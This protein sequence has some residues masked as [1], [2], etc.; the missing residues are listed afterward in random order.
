[1]RIQY[2]P[3]T[4]PPFQQQMPS[5][6]QQYQQNFTH[7]I[8]NIR[9]PRYTHRPT[10]TR[11]SRHAST[12][13]FPQPTSL[14]EIQSIPPSFSK[15]GTKTQRRFKNCVEDA[16]KSKQRDKYEPTLIPQTNA[17]LSRRCLSMGYRR[18]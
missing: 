18:V 13:A 10:Y 16:C 14:C 3:T 1:M 15:I 8:Y 6:D 2:A 5:L 17:L 9:Y 7:R 12:Y 4:D 11:F